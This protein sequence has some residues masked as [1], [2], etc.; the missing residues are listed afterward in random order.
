MGQFRYHLKEPL[1]LMGFLSDSSN[2]ACMFLSKEGGVVILKIKM[3]EKKKILIKFLWLTLLNFFFFFFK[4]LSFYSI[5]QKLNCIVNHSK[6]IDILII[7]WKNYYL[8]FLFCFLFFV[9]FF[10]PNIDNFIFYLNFSLEPFTWRKFL[11]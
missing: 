5:W 4:F 6:L 1:Y 11:K 3:I 8:Q 10:L 2:K 7:L 9:F